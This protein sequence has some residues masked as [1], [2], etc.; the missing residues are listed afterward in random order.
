MVRPAEGSLPM[1]RWGL[2]A[3]VHRGD[4]GVLFARFDR[5]A[6]GPCWPL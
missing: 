1:E 4:S 2:P 5:R 6:A 3:E